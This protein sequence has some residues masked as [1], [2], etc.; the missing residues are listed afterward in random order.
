MSVTKSDHGTQMR[1]E[2]MRAIIRTTNTFGFPPTIRELGKSVGLNSPASVYRH[3]EKLKRDGWLM[4][5]PGKRNYP[6]VLSVTTIGF[7]NTTGPKGE[8][9]EFQ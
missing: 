6:R 3:I 8:T 4:D 9:C 7:Q 2:I 5:Y 1:Q